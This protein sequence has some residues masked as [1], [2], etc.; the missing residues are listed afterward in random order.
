MARK[1]LHIVGRMNRGGVETWL[2]GVFR[3]IDRSRYQMDV[4]V[5]SLQPGSY[6]QELKSMGA[7][8]W[9]LPPPSR[10]WSYVR[11]LRKLL[12]EHGPYDVVHSHI[13][14]YSGLVLLTARLAG[15]PVRI[16]H[17]HNDIRPAEVRAS[18]PRR[19]Y[20]ALTEW[21]IKRNATRGFACSTKAAESLF[22]SDWKKDPRWKVLHYGVDLPAAEGRID[23]EKLLREFN[24][25]RGAYVVGHVGRFD[26]Q[27]NHTFLVEIAAELVRSDPNVFVLLVG[28]GSL[29]ADIEAKVRTSGLVGNVRFALVRSDVFQIMNGVMDV[30]LFPSLH[31]GLGLVLV[32]AQAAGLPCICS[33]VVP[34]EAF[35]L[36]EL[37][38]TLS[39]DLPAS[40]WA[41]AVLARK[42]QPRPVAQDLAFHSVIESR[43]SQQE[44][45]AKLCSEYA[46]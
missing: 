24:I 25:P 6:D 33:D 20:F 8:I 35:V 42:D 45:L 37:V 15:V 4:A 13:H 10:P 17:S 46:A 5:H 43:F 16:A 2:M 3:N 44:H 28:D 30:L 41:E 31:E 26:K 12:R 38:T 18:L 7:M 22:G 11:C 39:L 19:F 9:H 32:E 40:T 29:R 14:H 36:P 27:K 34:E 23:R 1:I 21:W